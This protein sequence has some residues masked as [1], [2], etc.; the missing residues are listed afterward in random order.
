MA[1]ELKPNYP[2]MQ[3]LQ[4]KIRRV[5]DL[6]GEEVKNI[7]G[8]VKA[9]YSAA[10]SKE[11]TLQEELAG[12]KKLALGL[13]DAAVGYKIL[14]REPDT[15]RQLYDAVLKR[16]KDVS[17]VAG[18]HTSNVSI[19][20]PAATPSAPSS[21][22]ELVDMIFAATLGLI[23]GIGTVFLMERLDNTIKTASEVQKWLRIP[24]LGTIPRWPGAFEQSAAGPKLVSFG[25]AGEPSND[26]TD[27][28]DHFLVRE[29]YRSLRAALLLSRPDRPPRSIVIT[30]ANPG[31]GKTLTAVNT[32]IA[33]AH[34]FSKVLLIDADLRGPKCHKYLSIKNHAGLTEL[35]VGIGEANGLMRETRVP[36][37]FL[38]SAGKV[39]PNS[40]ELLASRRMKRLLEQLGAQFDCI[41][42]DAPPLLPVSD[43]LLLGSLT[44]GVVLVVE[45][46]VTP[47][48]Q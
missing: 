17:V 37:M 18:A 44:D 42:I 21:P 25:Q 40:A 7:A 5:Q 38:L 39:P 22:R 23:A 46:A 45:A 15:N 43:G 32:A 28:D 41:V 13:S 35:L 2:P 27:E 47:K 30:S 1:N 14:Q 24:T 33:L 29:S 36:G 8:S 20:D 11:Q 12:Q 4:V 19:V 6:I 31:E 34:I 3:E 48:L 26:V 10:L 9:R 16:M